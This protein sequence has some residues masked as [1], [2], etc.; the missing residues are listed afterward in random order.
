MIANL[1]LAINDVEAL[2]LGTEAV[3]LLEELRDAREASDRVRLIVR[4]LKLFSRAEEDRRG[5]VV[6][7]T[8]G[9]TAFSPRGHAPKALS[10]R[11]RAS[12]GWMSPT[13]AAGK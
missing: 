2:Q 8:G 11:A 6:V 3:E 9:T 10:T 13:A 5:A 7:G 12:A 4:D 1:E